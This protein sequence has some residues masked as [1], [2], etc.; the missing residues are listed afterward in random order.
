MKQARQR[1]QKRDSVTLIGFGNWGTALASALWKAKIPIRE[2]VVRRLRASDEK[3]ARRF[4]ARLVT[5]EAVGKRAATL[6]AE[7][8]W[9]C[10]PDAA[11]AAMAA[12]LA[13]R[14]EKTGRGKAKR[15]VVLHSSGAL[16]STELASVRDAGASVASVH[17]MMSFPR[18]VGAMGE[19]VSLR[20]V[21]FAME[22]DARAIRAARRVVRELGGEPFAIC[23][24]DKTMYH[25]FGTFAS[26]LVTALLMAAVQVGDAAGLAQAD[27]M[28]RMRPMVEQTV[29][30]FFTNGPA[31]SL[32]GPVARG[33]GLTVQR[34]LTALETQRE[35]K[36]IYRALQSFAVSALPGKEKRAMREILAESGASRAR[37]NK[38]R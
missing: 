10:T 17:P 36:E 8:V 1:G 38:A 6:D 12:M 33:D 7:I 16:A 2:I 31:K 18:R 15:P 37:R 29:A 14:W 20:S 28:R 35:W 22:G 27:A 30:N 25:A 5:L 23:T 34:H 19:V 21:P 24:E 26:P 32:S 9:I 13:E 4:G 3:L 11:I